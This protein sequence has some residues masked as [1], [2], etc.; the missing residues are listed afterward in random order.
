[1]LTGALEEDGDLAGDLVLKWEGCLRIDSC[2]VLTS[3]LSN[4]YN[5]FKK[6]T[7]TVSHSSLDINY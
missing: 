4:I 2:S 5:T 1:M 7:A 3:I 6:K